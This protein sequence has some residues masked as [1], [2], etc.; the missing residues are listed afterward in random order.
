ME[1]S[2][3]E[4]FLLHEM[5]LIIFFFFF[6]IANRNEEGKKGRESEHFKF[7]QIPSKRTQGSVLKVLVAF[8]SASSQKS[9]NRINA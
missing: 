7:P 5:K 3:L 2:S 6:Q 8:C 4:N 1:P 9:Q